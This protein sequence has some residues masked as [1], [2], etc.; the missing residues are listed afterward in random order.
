VT[1][2]Y[3]D[4]QAAADHITAAGKAVSQ[5]GGMAN[6]IILTA[7][8]SDGKGWGSGDGHTV[9]HPAQK[10]RETIIPKDD[11]NAEAVI[12]AATA[13]LNGIAKLVGDDNPDV[14]QA[15]GQLD[16]VKKTN[17]QG[18]S[19]LDFNVF[20]TGLMA[21]PTQTAAKMHQGAK[22]GGHHPLRRAPEEEP[23]QTPQGGGSEAPGEAQPAGGTSEAQAAPAAQ[24]TAPAGAAA[25]SG[26]TP[27]AVQA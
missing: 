26:G 9:A 2:P 1:V 21:K 10:M 20:I 19:L 24:E 27:A 13:Y 17:G 23:S 14:T 6:N 5:A 11:E 15:K 16:F 8:H 25:P 3:V 22:D 4:G 7:H 18:M 12:D